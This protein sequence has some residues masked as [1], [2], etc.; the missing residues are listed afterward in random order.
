MRGEDKMVYLDNAATSRFVPKCVLKAFQEQLSNK[1]NPGRGGYEDSINAALE[2]FRTRQA[3]LNH[4]GNADGKVVF[5][6]NCTEA[7]NLAIFGTAKK[8]HVISTVTEHNSV[9]RPLK[10]LEK[11]GVIRLTLVEPDGMHGISADTIRKHLK[12]DTYL[13]CINHCSNVTGTKNDVENICRLASRYGIRTL[14]DDAQGAGHIRLD[15]KSSG[16]DMVASAGHKG[17]HGVQGTGFL[18]YKGVEIKPILYGGTGTD[19]ISVYQPESSPEGLEAGT[20]NTAGICALKAGIEWTEKNFSALA[21]DNRG[22]TGYLL[23]ELSLIKGTRIFSPSNSCGVV[24]FIIQGYTSE[25]IADYL[26]QCGYEVRA[27]LHCAPLM[28]KYLKTLDT[29]L[30][31]ISVGRNNTMRDMEGVIRHIYRFAKSSINKK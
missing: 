19:S 28:H 3:I 18:T 13:I 23:E 17:L 2:V 26:N 14:V 25:E 29:G 8:G 21:R 15:M 16:I 30:V 1:V 10:E 5:T 27:G 12:T 31:R 4:Y 24:S 22:M 11:R 20:L 6:K 9:L 7:L